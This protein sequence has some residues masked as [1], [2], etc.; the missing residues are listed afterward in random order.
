MTF[1]SGAA[2]AF[3][4][5]RTLQLGRAHAG[6]P[7]TFGPGLSRISRRDKHEDLTVRRVA[8]L[9]FVPHS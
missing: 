4:Q 5:K 2:A 3:G 6:R 1:A 8:D 7:P 9:H